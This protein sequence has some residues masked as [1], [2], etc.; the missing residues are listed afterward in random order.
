MKNLGR[1]L[2]VLESAARARFSARR[3]I[4]TSGLSAGLLLRLA[5]SRGDLSVLTDDDL[6]ELEAAAHASAG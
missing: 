1:R 6:D 2:A 3:P 5:E 4:D